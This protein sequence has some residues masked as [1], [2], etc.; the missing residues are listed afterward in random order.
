MVNLDLLILIQTSY[1]WR[2]RVSARQAERNES[3]EIHVC[4]EENPSLS[5][6]YKLVF[7]SRLI[8]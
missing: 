1:R 3:P 7:V 6:N 5:L 2:H 8:S 4:I